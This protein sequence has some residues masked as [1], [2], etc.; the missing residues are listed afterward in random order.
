MKSQTEMQETYLS[1]F[2]IL[3]SLYPSIRA[4]QALEL[5]IP[6][7]GPPEAPPILAA[8]AMMIAEDPSLLV[9]L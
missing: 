9:S 8:I 2:C 3:F 5:D 1:D 7:T 6:P 4:S